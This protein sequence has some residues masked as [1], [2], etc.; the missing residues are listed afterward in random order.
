VAKPQRSHIHVGVIATKVTKNG[1]TYLPLAP[2][3]GFYQTKTDY[4]EPLDV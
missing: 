3:G 1:V 4:I 2:K